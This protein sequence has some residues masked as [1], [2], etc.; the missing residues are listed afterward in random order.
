M[1]EAT[2]PQNKE[3]KKT[4]Q[5]N[6]KPAYIDPLSEATMDPLSKMVADVSFKEKVYVYDVRSDKKCLY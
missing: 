3:T 2:S 4:T 5:S 6:S 1:L